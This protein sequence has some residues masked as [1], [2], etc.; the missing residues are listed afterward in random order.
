[1]KDEGP[2][3]PTMDTSP[4]PMLARFFDLSLDLLCVLKDDHALKVNPAFARVLGYPEEELLEKPF[5]SFVHPADRASTSTAW[6]SCLAGQSITYFEN[7]LRH[8]DGSHRWLAWSAQ[9]SPADGV[10]YCVGRDVTAHKEQEAEAARLQVQL[11]G[12]W[13]LASMV[14]AD[15]QSLCDQVLVELLKM[16]K[17]QYAFYGF[18]QEDER[19]LRVYSWSSAA[20]ADCRMRDR[21][22]LFSIAE[23]GIWAES[24]RQRRPLI[25]N[26]Y[27]EAR[28]PAAKGLPE[29]HVPLTRLLSVP[30]FRNERIVALAVVANKSCA[31]TADDRRQVEAFATNVQVILDRRRAEEALR[32]SE[33]AYRTLAGN[34]PA[35]VYRVLVKEN[36]R[37]LFFNGLLREMTGYTDDELQAGAVC[38]ID[39]LIVPEDRPQVNE[40]VQNA[41]LD[42]IPFRIEYRLRRKDGEI[43]CFHERG[44]PIYGA[45][46]EAF[47]ID[48]IIFDVTE[49]KRI[50]EAL[51]AAKDELEHRVQERTAELANAKEMLEAVIDH[52]PVMLRVFDPAKRTRM[53]NH[54]YER[55]VGWSFEELQHID[56]LAECYPD[57]LYRQ[58]VVDFIRKGAPGWRDFRLRTREGRELEALWSNVHLSDGSQIGIGIDITER[59]LKER[60]LREQNELLETVFANVNFL[61]AYMDTDFNFI[62]VNRAYAEADDRTPEFFVGENH[63]ALYPNAENEAIFREVAATGVP[64]AVFE[65]PFEYAEH[66]ERGVTYWDWTLHPVQDANGAVTGLVLSLVNVTKRVEAQGQLR[67]LSSQLLT[68]QEKERRYVAQELHDSIA[69]SLVAVKIALQNKLRQMGRGQSPPGAS[70]EE[71]IALTEGTIDELRRLMIDLRPAILDDLGILATVNWYCKE[72]QKTY[73]HVQVEKEID[74]PARLPDPL[75]ITLF[76]ILQEALHNAARHGNADR[77]R[78]SLKCDDAV[79]LAIEDNGV[80]FDMEEVT[81]RKRIDTGL[82]LASMKERAELAGGTLVI[83]SGRGAGTTVRGFWPSDLL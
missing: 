32:E 1:M 52:I 42:R 33:R 9:P 12:L 63:F 76:R 61:V 59:K 73:P 27:R 57:P 5:L 53:V 60:L 64:Y 34:L 79:R 11:A 47:Y 2:L 55:L 6:Q 46:G 80:G 44:R 10:V 62:R 41:V 30:V 83:E 51:Q 19:A 37:M 68:A 13:K 38:S 21:P 75:E 15:Y 23:G 14:E 18:I 70:L 81:A 22:Q 20:L 82:G 17:S 49:S 71:I 28:P 54:E 74:L 58:E 45:D 66:P 7:R 4:D 24:V 69:S 40:A 78:V 50:E 77:I 56:V 31:Y 48:G 29:G 8:G 65:K 67:L 26:A 3:Q 25:I 43:R 35:L 39:P 36:N 72:F 16:T